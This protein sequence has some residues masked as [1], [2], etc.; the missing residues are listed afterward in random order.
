[1][2]RSMARTNWFSDSGMFA[3]DSASRSSSHRAYCIA[4]SPRSS[5]S[6]DTIRN[7][8]S[9]VMPNR[10]RSCR[11]YRDIC[12]LRLWEERKKAIIDKMPLPCLLNECELHQKF[13]EKK[14]IKT[15]YE[16][17]QDCLT[18]SI[19]PKWQQTQRLS[20]AILRYIQIPWHHNKWYRRVI[21]HWHW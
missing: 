15:H 4:Q 13:S 21:E 7:C 8:I 17:Y 2:A 3:H 19:R 10:C 11:T 9:P 5:M 6:I 12:R 14:K 20:W 16:C 1:M 18:A